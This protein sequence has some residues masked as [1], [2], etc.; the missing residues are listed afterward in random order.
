MG[1]ICCSGKSLPTFRDNLSDWTDRFK[2]QEG[3]SL[4]S[5]FNFGRTV[6]GSGAV[7][8]TSTIRTG[9]A[10]IQRHLPSLVS[11]LRPIHT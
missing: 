7:S 9:S 4:G 3:L 6:T 5:G 2:P 11:Q 8:G 1:P 10:A